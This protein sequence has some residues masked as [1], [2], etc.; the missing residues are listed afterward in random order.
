MTAKTAIF[1]SISTFF[2]ADFESLDPEDL[3]ALT[4]KYNKTVYQ[5]EKGLPPNGVV[6]M[7]KERV[8]DMRDK[9]C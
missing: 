4:V 5:I 6:P 1:Y 3:S 7:L 9:V 2:Q 8:E